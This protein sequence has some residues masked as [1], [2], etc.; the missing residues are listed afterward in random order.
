MITRFIAVTIL[1]TASLGA[2]EPASKPQD[3]VAVYLDVAPIGGDLWVVSSY[4][5]RIGGWTKQS[6]SIGYKRATNDGYDFMPVIELP[7][8]ENDRYMIKME[9]GIIRITRRDAYYRGTGL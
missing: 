6:C 4:Y 1:L 3:L 9:D 7:D 5:S 2:E 8:L